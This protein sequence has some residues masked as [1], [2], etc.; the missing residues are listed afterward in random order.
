MKAEAKAKAP[1]AVK[2]ALVVTGQ[3]SAQ[4]P[5]SG[6]GENMIVA[7]KNIVVALLVLAVVLV[8]LVILYIFYKWVYIRAFWFSNT[9][10]SFFEFVSD[11]MKDIVTNMNEIGSGIATDPKSIETFYGDIC[12]MHPILQYVD[13]WVGFLGYAKQLPYIGGERYFGGNSNKGEEAFSKIM[14][15]INNVLFGPTITEFRMDITKSLELQGSSKPSLDAFKNAM[16]ILLKDPKYSTI[17]NLEAMLTTAVCEQYPILVNFKLKL[18]D[19]SISNIDM[20]FDDKPTSDRLEKLANSLNTA[21]TTFSELISFEA[22]LSQSQERIKGSIKLLHTSYNDLFKVDLTT[23]ET[24]SIKQLPDLYIIMLQPNLLLKKDKKGLGRMVTFFENLDAGQEIQTYIQKYFEE[25]KNTDVKGIVLEEAITNWN[26]ILD[27]LIKLRKET[28]KYQVLIN[29]IEPIMKISEIGSSKHFNSM[30]YDDMRVQILELNML[31]NEYWGDLKGRKNNT[32]VRLSMFR[33]SGG[34]FNFTLV[35]LYMIDYYEFCILENVVPLW[36]GF[37]KKITG[38]ADAIGTWMSSSEMLSFFMSLPKKFAGMEEDDAS[39]QDTVET[40]VGAIMK[41]GAAFVSIA[42]VFLSIVNVI[43]DPIAFL[44][45]LIGWVVAILL[46]IVWMIIALPPFLILYGFVITMLSSWWGSILWILIFVVFCALYFLLSILDIFFGGAIMRMLRCENLPSVW[47]QRNNWHKGNKYDR[48]L[49]CASP[50]RKSF[51]PFAAILCVRQSKHEPTYA[52]HQLVYTAYKREG[53]LSSQR[54]MI[55]NFK[56]NKALYI[57]MTGKMKIEN[58]KDAYASEQQYVKEVRDKYST[59]EK[60]VE[61]ICS[62]HFQKAE[63]NSEMMSV[64]K[65][66]FCNSEVS[67]ATMCSSKDGKG[68]FNTPP[69]LVLV[70]LKLCIATLVMYIVLE[71]YSEGSR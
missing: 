7:I 40:F 41:I 4:L 15:G 21:S 46:L 69:P 20:F 66:I 33:Q 18:W 51:S 60:L 31:L 9:E 48:S 45:F 16:E 71:Q 43:T 17:V 56:F 55:F 6:Q 49:F 3:Q 38:R 12:F 11:Y 24:S 47:H 26:T 50:C 30:F 19:A 64:C 53:F 13:E 37:G 36:V 23:I 28:E 70:F 25:S 27:I 62:R 39:K 1:G 67:N 42:D 54:N 10:S 8:I 44:K 5:E 65:S 63:K 34:M 61:G 68:N 2:N 35:W 22:S 59:Y 14:N 52:P 58:W 29:S 32:I 57:D